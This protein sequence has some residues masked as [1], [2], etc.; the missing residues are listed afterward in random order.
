MTALISLPADN[1]KT[2]IQKSLK[3]DKTYSG[4]FDCF[5]KTVSREGPL[6]LWTGFPVYLLRGTP[7]SFILITTQSYL[8]NLYRSM[9]QSH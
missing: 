8:L 6:S 7:H 4:I 5:V 1:I 2:K 3:L 9:P